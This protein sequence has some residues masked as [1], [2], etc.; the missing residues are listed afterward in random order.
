MREERLCVSQKHQASTLAQLILDCA[1]C[2]EL[3]ALDH[4]GGGELGA[5]CWERSRH[6]RHSLQKVILGSIHFPHSLPQSLRANPGVIYETE[7]L[8]ITLRITS[9][10]ESSL[11]ALR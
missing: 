1:P 5:I 10:H 3:L 8:V 6:E 9:L 4:K 2:D 11:L 7:H